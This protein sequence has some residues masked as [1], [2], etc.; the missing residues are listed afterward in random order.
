MKKRLIK[1]VALLSMGGAAFQ[2]GLFGN[3]CNNFGLN[4]LGSNELV[5]NTDLVNFYTAVGNNSIN[6]LTDGAA[7]SVGS[8]FA[9]IFATPTN[10][11]F[12]SLWGNFVAREFPADPTGSIRVVEQ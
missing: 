7:A 6:A 11:F 9:A 10:S 1:A 2:F 8:D 3:G 12:Q 5:R 4:G